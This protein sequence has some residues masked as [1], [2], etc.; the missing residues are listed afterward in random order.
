[1]T[2][3]RQLAYYRSHRKERIAYSKRYRKAHPAAI[4]KAQAKLYQKN[5]K[6]RIAYQ[7]A[8]NAQGKA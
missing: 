6:A 2:I 3:S 7:K 4:A 5:R 8:Y 1:M